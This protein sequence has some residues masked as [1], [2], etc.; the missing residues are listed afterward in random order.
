MV[1]FN[2]TVLIVILNI[3][4]QTLN[5]HVRLVKK[6]ETQLNIVY[7]KPIVILIHTS[8]ILWVW[9]QITAINLQQ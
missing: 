5:S 8:E 9:F 4:I 3:M 7:R 2:S 1:D 6:F